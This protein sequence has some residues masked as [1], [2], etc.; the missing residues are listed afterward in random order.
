MDILL[1][2]PSILLAI[3]FIPQVVPSAVISVRERD[4]IEAER[5]L[6]AG[7]AQIR[8]PRRSHRPLRPLRQLY[9]GWPPRRHGPAPQE[10]GD[11]FKLLPT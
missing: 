7:S 11:S 5:T 1:V 4:Y 3:V 2:L 8:L 6:G 9:R 10:V